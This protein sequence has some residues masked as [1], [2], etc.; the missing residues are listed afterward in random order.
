M[1]GNMNAVLEHK[2]PLA[3]EKIP[4]L[5][6]QFAVPSIIAM[7]I[8]SLYNIVDQIY[9]GHIEGV[10]MLGNAAT[11]VA[12]PLTTISM[13][14]ALL[15]GAG[16]AAT[17]SLK[18]GN[19]K[20]KEAEKSVGCAI[21]MAA[22]FSIPYAMLVEAFLPQIL[23]LFGA[24]ATVLPYS[25]SYVRWTALGMPLLIFANVMECLIRAD[26][27]PKS[28]MACMVTG[29]AANIILD[30]VFIFALGLG[31]AGA[32][33]AT[34]ISQLITFVLV[35]CYLLRF[36]QIRL[37]K[38]SFQ[39]TL[40]DCL[41]VASLGL[42]GCLTQIAITAVQITMNHTLTYY[43]ARSIYGAD[44]PLS[45]FGI[46]MKINSIVISVFVGLHQ[47]CQPIFGYNYGARQYDRVKA[48]YRQAIRWSLCVASAAFL[49]FQFF[50]RYLIAA[51]GKGNELYTEFAVRFMRT[52]LFLVMVNG[53]QI[54]SS[55]MFSAI[56]KPIKGVLLSL[57]RQ[58]IVLVPMILILPLFFGI[59]G[60][61]YAGPVS[62]LAA[63]AVSAFMVYREFQ[64]MSD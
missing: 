60:A 53:I 32:A 21:W 55:N 17:F 46:V 7:L 35:A 59:D 41:K 57:S 42:S 20:P 9:I 44:I 26:G 16:S 40:R 13:A 24:T 28:S 8:G 43:G 27:S 47:G 49:V 4:Q 50:P 61:M 58:F 62:D 39:V 51:F 54:I 34:V 23:R 15:I 36:K 29:A 38:D 63:F 1:E 6:R 18:L 52:F 12:F 37:A 10:G 5:I 25:I 48:V 45:A 33:I 2:N 3:Y 22:A 19:Q 14:I 11:N 64:G 56:G 31:V 30:P